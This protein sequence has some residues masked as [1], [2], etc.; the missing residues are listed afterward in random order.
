M[1]VPRRRER[2]KQSIHYLPNR[3]D[4]AGVVKHTMELSEVSA[5]AR[6]IYQYDAWIT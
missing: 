5:S 1:V 4:K 3:Q 6:T 2:L